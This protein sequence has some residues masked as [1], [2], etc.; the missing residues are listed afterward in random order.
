[1]GARPRNEP[2]SRSFDQKE[3]RAGILRYQDHEQ[4]KANLKKQPSV[5]MTCSLQEQDSRRPDVAGP[6]GL[7]AVAL[8]HLGPIAYGR[9]GDLCGHGRV[10]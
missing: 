1:M 5:V 2:N 7:Q 3:Q 9:V 6:K 4:G 10:P 8:E